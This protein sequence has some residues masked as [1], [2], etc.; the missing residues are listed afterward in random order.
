MQGAGTPRAPSSLNRFC[1]LD[2]AWCCQISPVMH[3][4][5]VVQRYPCRGN[6]APDADW[7][8]SHVRA[9]AFFGG[10]PPAIV[11]DR[12]KSGVSKAGFLEPK[13]SPT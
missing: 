4:R 3:Q 8:G 9:L 13:L 1:Q 11:P 10:W 2:Q 5:H 7:I 6:P 12:L